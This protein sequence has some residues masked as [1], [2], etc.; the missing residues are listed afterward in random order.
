MDST[1]S[2][3]YENI[4]TATL[5]D[6][7]VPGIS[8]IVLGFLC[9]EKIIVVSNYHG[10]VV[11]IRNGSV[12]LCGDIKDTC[13]CSY[14]LNDVDSIYSTDHAFAAKRYGGIVVTWGDAIEGGDSSSVQAELK[15]GVDT[16][17]S[18]EQAFAAKLLDGR[19]VTWGNPRFGGDSSSVQAELKKGV[20]TIYSSKDGF[21][22]KLLDG[23]VVTWGYQDYHRV[24]EVQAS[25]MDV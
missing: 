15:N 8:K 16:I 17:Y 10:I 13:L 24:Q 2:S 23:S 6:I 21:T 9:H 18:T 11:R 3:Q 20:E 5:S 12:V 7:L 19:V 22:A 1:S 4:V 14:V 25:L